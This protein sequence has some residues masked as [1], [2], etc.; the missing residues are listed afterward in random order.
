MTKIPKLLLIAAIVGAAAPASAVPRLISFQGR[1]ADSTNTGL[2]GQYSVSFSLFPTTSGG[3]ACFSETQS[4][5]ANS[6]LFNV[7]IGSATTGGVQG[8]CNF[9]QAYY[10][11][12]KVGND[13][14]MSPRIVVAAVPYAL[15]ADQVSGYGAGNGSGNVPLSNGAVNTNLNAAMVNGAA[16]PFQQQG[17]LHTMTCVNVT[18]YGSN[19]SVACAAGYTMMGCSCAF[20]GSQ[21]AATLGYVTA[22]G[23]CQVLGSNLYAY[24]RCCKINNP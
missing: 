15:N 11:E 13:T 24:G 10:L 20:G 17:V 14:P 3:S 6:G 8:T 12:I 23:T 5:A 19:P 7:N 4:V 21:C 16:G 1:L 9:T 18:A 22:A 2:T